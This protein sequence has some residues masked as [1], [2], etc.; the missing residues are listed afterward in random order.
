MGIEFVLPKEL[1]KD[2]FFTVDARMETAIRRRI[3]LKDR[4]TFGRRPAMIMKTSEEGSKDVLEHGYSKC[5]IQTSICDPRRI[6][7]SIK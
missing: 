6:H 3:R 5:L 7:A 2:G 1:A 4:F